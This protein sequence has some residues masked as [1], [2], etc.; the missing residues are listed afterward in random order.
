MKNFLD[1]TDISLDSRLEVK[2]QLIEHN[3]PVYT[4]KINNQ[5]ARPTMHFALLDDFNFECQ[6]SEGAIEVAS[7][8]INGFEIMP[9]Y[10]H[11]ANPATNWITNDWTMVI[12]GPF[13]PWYHQITG[14]G[15]IA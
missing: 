3:N 10:Q 13:Y 1:A 8:T 7:I 11:L 2:I 9:I 12:P 4:F 5:P 15:W 14:Q 6:I